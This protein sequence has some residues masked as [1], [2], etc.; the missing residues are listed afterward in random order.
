M[1]WAFGE[2]ADWGVKP[3]FAAGATPAVARTVNATA[4]THQSFLRTRGAFY[5]GVL[6]LAD[7]PARSRAE[8]LRR[9]HRRVAAGSWRR[10][11]GHRTDA[12]LP[13][14]DRA[15]GAPGLLAVDGD[16]AWDCRLVPQARGRRR[17]LPGRRKAA[18]RDRARAEA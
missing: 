12:R 16:V 5:G 2:C 4:T 1:R 17:R 15:G 9:L 13:S 3:P 18:R 11:R 10:L 6:A 8:R 7:R 14:S